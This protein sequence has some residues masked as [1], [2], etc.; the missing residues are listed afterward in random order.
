M[1]LFEACLLSAFLFALFA[2]CR[3]LARHAPELLDAPLV[4]RLL[5]RWRHRAPA[6][7]EPF[8]HTVAGT[9]AL[10]GSTGSEM[11]WPPPSAPLLLSRRASPPSRPGTLVPFEDYAE[12][13]P[14]PSTQQPFGDDSAASI[15]VVFD[16]DAFVAAPP[17]PPL[18]L[19]EVSLPTLANYSPHDS[20][21]LPTARRMPA[22]RPALAT[23][24]DDMVD[25]LRR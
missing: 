4:A 11:P 9:F 6:S 23:L 20:G 7:M 18:R 19:P 17:A 25:T 10:H 1:W 15:D 21:L 12:A 5:H 22:C 13:P 3:E 2:F 16:S 14:L 24:D 8:S